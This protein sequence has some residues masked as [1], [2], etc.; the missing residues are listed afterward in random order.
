[1]V[2]LAGMGTL[3]LVKVEWAAAVGGMVGLGGGRDFAPGSRSLELADLGLAGYEI[4]EGLLV[5]LVSSAW[6]LM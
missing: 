1:M 4:P 6:K 5:S 3:L 2:P